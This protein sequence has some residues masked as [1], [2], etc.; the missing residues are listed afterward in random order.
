MWIH[1]YKNRCR[2]KANSHVKKPSASE[3]QLMGITMSII[4]SK[5]LIQ[6]SILNVMQKKCA[7]SAF[8]ALNVFLLQ[9]R[10]NLGRVKLEQT[11]PLIAH[12]TINKTQLA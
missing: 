9:M 6:T 5:T 12:F 7:F 2:N 1:T 3:T 4:V 10:F 11:S 8:F